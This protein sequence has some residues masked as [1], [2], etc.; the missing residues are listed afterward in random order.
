MTKVGDLGV[1]QYFARAGGEASDVESCS[2]SRA[3]VPVKQKSSAYMP[4]P[5]AVRGRVTD[6]LQWLQP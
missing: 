1:K 3:R 5:L 2:T 6:E 4:I